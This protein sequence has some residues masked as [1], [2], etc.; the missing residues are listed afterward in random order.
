MICG[1]MPN[2]RDQEEEQ[3]KG[4]ARRRS[5]PL[6]VRE[7]RIK[8]R[9]FV[10]SGVLELGVIGDG[11]VFGLLRAGA[12]SLRLWWSVGFLY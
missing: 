11:G 10:C 2:G 12:L 4:T 5:W 6:H 7:Q 3:K 9:R 1:R 8:E